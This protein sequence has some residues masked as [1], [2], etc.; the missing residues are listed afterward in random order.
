MY[1]CKGQLRILPHARNQHGIHKTKDLWNADVILVQLK[2]FNLSMHK[3]ARSLS[4]NGILRPK[5]GNL[6]RRG[7]QGEFWHAYC[8]SAGGLNRIAKR[9]G[10]Q[11]RFYCRLSFV[12]KRKR[13]HLF[14]YFLFFPSVRFS[15]FKVVRHLFTFLKIFLRISRRFHRHY[16]SLTLTFVN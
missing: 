15:S 2:I 16:F 14:V 11:N 10:V 12:K 7:R 1:K 4:I 9:V 3:D 6:C 13:I 5:R 8:N